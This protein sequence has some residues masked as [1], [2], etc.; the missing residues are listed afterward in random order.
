MRPSCQ[1][2]KIVPGG[3]PNNTPDK[4]T[5]VSKT[6]F[7]I[8]SELFGRRRQ[9]PLFSFLPYALVAVPTSAVP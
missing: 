9:Y 4:K 6:I 1:A 3:P 7:T 5:L 8:V 2:S